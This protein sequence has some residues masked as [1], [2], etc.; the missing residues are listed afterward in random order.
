MHSL[1]VM[2]GGMSTRFGRPKQLEPVGPAGET[3][4]E[5]SVHDALEAGFGRVVVILRS[6]V[7][8]PFRAQVGERLERAVEVEYVAQDLAAY[9]RERSRPWGTAHAVLAARDALIGSAFGVVN[10]DDFYGR[11]SFSLLADALT[12][13]STRMA[14]VCFELRNTLSEFGAVNRGVCQ[15]DRDG[16]LRDVSEFRGLEA[17]GGRIVGLDAGGKHRVLSG[18]EMVS[19]NMWGFQST[20]LNALETSWNAFY[21]N[22]G[23]SLD[24]E[25]FLP[26]VVNEWMTDRGWVCQVQQT[27][28]R[29]LGLTFP[30][31]CPVAVNRLAEM[32]DA[33]L[34]RSPLFT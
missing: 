32:V 3:L 7:I 22:S 12:T 31:D 6:E 26:S 24:S 33:G 23:G 21:R 9:G 17:Q 16:L 14:A 27:S 13:G 34:Y 29:W 30:E 10:A 4:L 1:V 11:Q 5:Y 19:M 28:E 18:A 8:M 25:F 2:A 20:V 15:L